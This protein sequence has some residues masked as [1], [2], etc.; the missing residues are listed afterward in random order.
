MGERKKG[1]RREGKRRFSRCYDG[2]SS[3]VRELKLVYATRATRGYRNPIFLSKL[4]EVGFSLILVPLYL[5][6]I[7]GRVVQ[8]KHV[9]KFLDIG[10]VFQTV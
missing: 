9:T 1:K 5:R 6:A 2:R 8:P 4:Q 3:I 10:T 7:N